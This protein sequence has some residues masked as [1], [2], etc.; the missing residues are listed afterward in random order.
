MSN[1]QTRTASDMIPF[2]LLQHEDAVVKAEKSLG[3]PDQEWSWRPQGDFS[4]ENLT[5]Y[6]SNGNTTT[7][8]T[9]AGQWDSGEFQ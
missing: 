3:E 4:V 2:A 1:L 9:F 6:A 7:R 5:I 8:Q